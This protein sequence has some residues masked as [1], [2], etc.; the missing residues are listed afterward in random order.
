[1]NGTTHEAN[2]LDERDNA[3]HFS[4]RNL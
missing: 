4:L 2:L 3:L 1:M